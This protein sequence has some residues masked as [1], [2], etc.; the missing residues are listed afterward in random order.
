MRTLSLFS[1]IGGMDRGLRSEGF[2]IVGLCEI[3]D[4]CRKELHRE[5][6]GVPLFG[7]IAKLEAKHIRHACGR[8][9]CIV[10]GFPC[11]DISSARRNFAGGIDA[12]ERSGLWSHVARLIRD[13]RPTYAILENV[14]ALRFPGRGMHRVLGDLAQIGFDAE[15]V[16]LRASDFG[17]PH[18]RERVFVV[19]YPSG[20]H[21][22][23][24]VQAD[25]ASIRFTPDQ[26][27]AVHCNAE[28][29]SDF[30]Q[31][32]SL[33]DQPHPEIPEPFF[34]P[35]DDGL[36]A[37]AAEYRAVGNAVCPFMAAHIG[38]CIQ[39]ARKLSHDQNRKSRTVPGVGAVGSTRAN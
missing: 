12:G 39:R 6:T 37:R 7:D 3:D 30:S 8:V 15:W 1:G 35:L 34:L 33:D 32:A 26:W 28:G 21:R 11:Q 31:L 5:F 24:I 4:Y 16:S 2:E 23:C 29:K 9:D 18:S 27:A 10:A 17:A 25:Q 22:D 19:A 36:K 38:R 14:S 20:Q 13:L